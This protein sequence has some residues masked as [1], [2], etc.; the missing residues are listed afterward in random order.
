MKAQVPE[1]HMPLPSSNLYSHSCRES[2]IPA[3]ESRV[4][5]RIDIYSRTWRNWFLLVGVLILTTF[6]LATSIPPLLS[7][8]IAN[9]W[10]W[11]KTDLVLLIGLSLIVLAFICYMTQQQRQVHSIHKSLHQLQA[12]TDERMN[13]YISRIYALSTVGRLMGSVSD[14]ESVFGQITDVCHKTFGSSRV[15][16]MV[17]E[18]ET[19]ELV[20]RSISGVSNPGIINTRQK[21]GEGIAG[22][23]A[24]HKKAL[25]LN[26]FE[27]VERHCG[28]TLHNPSIQ[29]AMVIP[30][31][32]RDELVGVLNVSSQ[33]EHVEYTEDDM[34]ALQVFAENA[35]ACIRHHEQANLLRQMISKLRVSS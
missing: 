6:G 16:L 32:A 21:V 22:W 9:P 33:D 10:P 12:E 15:S 13:L 4:P 17:Y 5:E 28:L 20:V 24:K 2:D 29:S 35:G 30:I 8:R 34:M 23:V 14:L 19:D 27:D 26:E 7:E 3:R 11:M 25:L 1:V 31:V 18:G